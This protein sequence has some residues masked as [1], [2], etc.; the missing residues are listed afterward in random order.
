MNAPVNTPMAFQQPPPCSDPR[1]PPNKTPFTFPAGHSSLPPVP[2][3]QVNT[4]PK[5][6]SRQPSPSQQT[7]PQPG[8]MSRKRKASG[9]GK[10]PNGLAMTQIEKQTSPLSSGM[11]N[12]SGTLSGAPSPFSPDLGSFPLTADSLYGQSGLPTTG[13]ATPAFTAGGPPTPSSHTAE[14]MIFP[15]NG[16]L[17]MDNPPQLFSAPATANPSRAPSPTQLREMSQGLYGSNTATSPNRGRQPMIYKIIPGEGP[18]SGGVEVTI[19][20]SGFTNDGLEVMF[21]ENR[22]ATT[23]FW[24]ETSL[25]C[26]LPPSA[27]AG[28]VP[29]SL[30]HPADPSRLILNG[31]QQPL[32]RY[33]DDDEHRLIR[34]ALTVLGNKIGG[35]ITDVAD[36]ARNILY[37]PAANASWGA[38]GSSGS[39]NGQAPNNSNNNFNKQ[40][41]DVEPG[42]L[43]V[44]EL[45]D[46]DDSPN[47]ARINLRRSS[48][49]TMLHLACS[50]G[51]AR[52]VAGLISRGANVDL[53]DKGGFTPLHMAAMNDHPEIVRR[54]IN[55]GADPTMR[56]LSGLTP[57][58][59]AQSRDVIKILRHIETHARSRSGGSRHSRVNSASSLRSLWDPPSMT[60]VKQNVYQE[61]AEEDS[62][63]DD[64][65]S[66]E[67]E[68]DYGVMMSPSGRRPRLEVP[69]SRATV[70]PAPISPG[71]AMAAVRDHFIAQIHQIQ[72][73]MA[74]QLQNL[75]QFQVPQM[76]QMPHNMQ[77]MLPD[78]QAHLQAPS[79][80][81]RI[82]SLVPNIR[83]SGDQS[84]TES[85]KWSSFFG[86]KETPPPSYEE[87]YPQKDLDTKQ[88]SA[89]QA[90]VDYEADQKYAALYDQDVAEAEAETTSAEA[91]GSGSGSREVPELLHVGRKKAITREQQENLQRAHAASLKTGSRDKMLWFFWVP[92]LVLILGAMLFNVIPPVLAEAAQTAV[93]YATSGRVAADLRQLAPA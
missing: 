46:L 54:L 79:V 80:V 11:Q 34:T 2:C 73:S 17:S 42:L 48:G 45:I 3:A 67:E 5:I 30:R 91:S 25:L 81:Q 18:K 70:P 68:R 62:E 31:T 55:K 52:F 4:A 12:E 59:V 10:V 75:P 71:V 13:A 56:T 65:D 63:S 84:S 36:I 74:M 32:F 66:D 16:S 44:L 37:G 82:S 47:K 78:A 27:R 39:T 92:V 41:P 9:P 69:G 28:A 1:D 43:R 89:A 60:P 14:Q 33:V 15:S 90:A 86:S 53:R 38:S 19:L 21:G 58:D 24:G 61:T 77:T 35:K 76:L 49:Q 88:A 29:V 87:I 8:P 7:A 57:A 64:I 40:E 22:A 72:Q 26:L 85:N 51:M 23:T 20:G 93:S 50:L 6:F 83:G